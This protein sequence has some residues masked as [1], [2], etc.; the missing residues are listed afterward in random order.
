MIVR[1][2]RQILLEDIL[3]IVS[4]FDILAHYLHIN[5]IPTV[6]NS[7][8]RKDSNASMGLYTKDGDKIY[9]TDFRTKERGGT[10]DLLGRLWSKSF[11]ETLEKI[12]YDIPNITSSI[13]NK[14]S[15]TDLSKIK[16]NFSDKIHLRQIIMS[17]NVELKVKVREWKDYD[18]SFWEE[19]GIS[20]KWLK[21][22]DIYPI[23][24]I[25][26]RSSKKEDW[27]I[28]PAEKYAYVYVE[29][30]DGKESIK[31]YQPFSDKFK[32]RNKHD[33]SVWDL[34]DK[35]PETGENL[36]IT[37][38]RKDALCLWEN[39]EIPSVSLQS[40]TY[41][42][43]KS[44]VDQLKKRFKNIYVLYDNDWKKEVNTGKINGMALAEKFNL[45]Y[46]EIPQ[47]ADEKDP[48]DIVKR[49]G[50]EALKK[51]IEILTKQ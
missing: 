45:K 8:L 13:T 16:S 35:L 38:S 37:S 19:S 50:R 5:K 33:A 41:L 51:L 22:G 15:D 46:I 44:V 43:K 25:F 31:I 23:S 1:G 20:L 47:E 39:T 18:I 2:R 36:I 28:I 17:S 26:T 10:I 11:E 21:F 27:V 49:W 6:I 40:E 42:P 34:W 14:Y 7:P 24:H 30:K 48:S 29:F 4:E 9:Y 12:Y 32:W 3:K